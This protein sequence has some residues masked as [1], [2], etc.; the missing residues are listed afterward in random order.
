MGRCGAAGIRPWRRLHRRREGDWTWAIPC[1]L[2]AVRRAR[3]VTTVAAGRRPLADSAGGVAPP[4]SGAPRSEAPVKT[5]A[6]GVRPPPTGLSSSDCDGRAGRGTAPWNRAPPYGG[7]YAASPRQPSATNLWADRSTAVIA[8]SSRKSARAK[9]HRG[10]P[11][12]DFEAARTRHR[13]PPHVRTGCIRRTRR[14]L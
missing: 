9:P 8:E 12:A 11:S 1:R 5:A 13:R 4:R 6:P 2:G 10:T 3:G 14:S 7:S